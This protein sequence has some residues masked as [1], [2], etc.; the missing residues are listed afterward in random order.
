MSE[1]ENKLNDNK[2]ERRRRRRRDRKSKE[3]IGRLT[4]KERESMIDK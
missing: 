1:R 4:A 3:K 2:K